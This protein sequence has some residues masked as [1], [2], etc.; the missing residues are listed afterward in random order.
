MQKQKWPHLR[1]M[2]PQ[3]YLRESSITHMYKAE[4]EKN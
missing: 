2:G 1:I 4:T 3:S